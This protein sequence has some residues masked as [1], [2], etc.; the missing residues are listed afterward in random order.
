MKRRLVNFALLALGLLAGYLVADR[1]AARVLAR[2]PRPFPSTR[3]AG[4]RL[5]QN[6][7]GYRDY[8]YPVGKGAGVF[9]VIAVGDSFTQ[10]RGVGL[11]DTWPKRLE[12]YLVTL[13]EVPGKRYEVLNWGVAGASTPS[14]V[15]RI[16]WQ[17]PPWRPDLVVVG[18]CL[19]DAED[20]SDRAALEELRRR[21]YGRIYDAG[22]KPRGFF[23]ERS[24]LARLAWT[25]FAATA[26]NRGYLA[27]HR[28][29]YREDYPGWR[30]TRDAIAGL[31]RWSR[32]SGTPVVAMVFPLFSWPL[33][34]AYPLADIH[35]KV[36]AAFEGAGLPC[37][38]LLGAYRGLDPI[39]LQA[40]PFLDPHPSDVAHRLAAE[41][42]YGFIAERGLL[43]ACTAP[44]PGECRR[45]PVA[46]PWGP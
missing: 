23:V 25:R 31:G 37:L 39:A 16:Q 13:G 10:G 17:S 42:L 41:A 45:R 24:A 26:A 29:L 21:T 8:Q 40:V 11:D 3:F 12:R 32:E 2:P 28:A 9:R 38:D 6:A 27:Y 34:D 14:E 18:F 5:V 46:P 33:D 30:T 19:N 15:A 22:A 44:D 4:V 36:C 35:R 43:P 7:Q 1:L 20:E